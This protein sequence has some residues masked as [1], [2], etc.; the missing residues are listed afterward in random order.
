MYDYAETIII[1]QYVVN[2]KFVSNLEG[3]KFYEARVSIGTN[4]HRTIVFAVES[5]S[6]IES[7]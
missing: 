7:R 4:E 1:I 5:M 3:T 6:F 2:E